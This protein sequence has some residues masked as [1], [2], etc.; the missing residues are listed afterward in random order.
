MSQ[1][2]QFSIVLFDISQFSQKIE[3][4]IHKYSIASYTNNQF[5]IIHN[6]KLNARLQYN[7]PD[8]IATM[9][10]QTYNDLGECIVFTPYVCTM[11]AKGQLVRILDNIKPIENTHK[12]DECNDCPICF[13][14]IEKNNCIRTECGHV[15]HASCLMR[16][17]AVNGYTCPYCRA[18]MV[19]KKVLTSDDDDDEYSFYG[20][21]DENEDE[22]EDDDDR[23]DTPTFGQQSINSRILTNNINMQN[24]RWL[25]QRANDE[26]TEEDIDNTAETMTNLLRM[27]R[28]EEIINQENKEQMNRLMALVEN[29]NI[30]FQDL[31][32]A[33][34][35]HSA[36][37]FRYNIYADNAYIKVANIL[38]R[39]TEQVIRT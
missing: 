2:F 28:E 20:S 7:K 13:E 22:D 10:P 18:D 14:T 25:F 19:D 6:T 24:F 1:K 15:F 17:T 8:N 30:T 11:N 4:T 21:D 36:H 23:L 34:A 27:E 35:C 31:I 39:L 12:K 37:E 3:K 5:E 26:E 9:S 38:D 32:Y 29:T 16:H 33:F